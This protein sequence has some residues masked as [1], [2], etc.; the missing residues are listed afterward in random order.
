MPAWTGLGVKSRTRVA[1]GRLGGAEVELPHP[2][3]QTARHKPARWKR[4][5]RRASI[6]V[7]P[8]R[9]RLVGPGPEAAGGP[10]VDLPGMV[11]RVTFSRNYALSLSRTC[12]CYCKYCAFATHQPHLHAPGAVQEMLDRA[13]G[14]PRA[15]ELLVLTGEAP[16][17]NPQVA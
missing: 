3:R 17:H 7:E 4:R 11:R 15:K 5:I 12:R 1:P 10:L 9:A 14:R 16:D 6:G 13:A 8:A 2:A